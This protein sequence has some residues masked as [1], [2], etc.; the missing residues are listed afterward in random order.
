[1]LNLLRQAALIALPS[2]D[3]DQRSFWL[4]CIGIR[5]DGVMVSAKNGAV[6]FHNTIENYQLVPSSHA[7]GRVLRK[8]G[9]GGVIFVA[10]VSRKDGS[11][12]MAR[13]CGMCQVRLKSFKVRKVYYTINDKQYGVWYPDSDTDKIFKAE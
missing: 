6:E 2:S 7:E 12:A 8:L 5:E 1:M 3:I 9:K 11:L 13:P 4:G 10:R